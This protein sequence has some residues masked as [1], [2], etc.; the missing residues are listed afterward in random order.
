MKIILN[1]TILS[2]L[3]LLISGCPFLSGNS[4]SQ[5][6]YYPDII[7]NGDNDYYITNHL[8]SRM[9][10]EILYTPEFSTTGLSATDLDTGKLLW[11]NSEYYGFE[12]KPVCWGDY[13]ICLLDSKPDLVFYNKKTSEIS[14]KVNIQSIEGSA[15]F[16]QQGYWLKLIENDLYIGCL[17][18]YNDYTEISN[19]LYRIS[20][21]DFS[22]PSI[23]EQ[24]I[25][26]E[27]LINYQK[28]GTLRV[29]PLIEN[30]RIY[31]YFGGAGRKI[32]EDQS[33]KNLSEHHQSDLSVGCYNLE[34]TLIWSTPLKKCGWIGGGTEVIQFFNDDK[35]F[36]TGA[37]GI[38]LLDKNT[39]ETIYEKSCDGGWEYITI[40]GDY[41][42]VP[43]FNYLKC[44][45]IPTGELVWEHQNLYTRD[46]KPVI[47]GD[48]VYVVDS[49]ALRKFDK[50]TGKLL[51]VNEKL[52]V[53]GY[54]SQRYMPHRD[55]ILYILQRERI[56]AIRMD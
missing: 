51:G 23:Q 14:G 41:A 19:R 2:L 4:Q 18:T 17:L 45:H 52:G 9:D 48:H 10:E 32:P 36:L 15:H 13:V 27:L 53:P 55:D 40:D 28:N 50:R 25:Q 24:E 20:L 56:V 38:A 49:D 33:P 21:N 29:E 47:Y 7:W 26:A 37:D 16:P 34:G 30:N 5:T 43:L 1:S 46:C 11:R 35:L 8:D 39:G 12:T 6:N 44:F 54:R 3:L 31:V 42:Y 22:L